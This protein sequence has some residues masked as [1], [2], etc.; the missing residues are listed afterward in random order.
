MADTTI[1]PSLMIVPWPM[2]P[3]PNCFVLLMHLIWAALALD[4]D[5]AGNSMAAR[6]AMMAMTISNSTSVKAAR[7]WRRLPNGSSKRIN[8]V[9]GA[10]VDWSYSCISVWISSY[11]FQPLRYARLTYWD[12][13]GAFL[14]RIFGPSHS[15]FLPVRKATQ[16]SSMISVR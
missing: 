15:N 2:K 3:R 13:S 4:L 1:R 16:P 6:M 5:K 12:A 9:P 7:P 14:A 10:S 8:R 11:R